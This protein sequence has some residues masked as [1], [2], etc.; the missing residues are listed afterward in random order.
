MP[1][2]QTIYRIVRLLAP[3]IPLLLLTT[4][5]HTL[6]LHEN[7]Q[8]WDLRMS[9]VVTLL[10]SIMAGPPTSSIS[11][12]QRF[13]SADPGIKGN[14]W[15][16][17]V[18]LPKPLEQDVL[19]KVL[20]AVEDLKRG[21]AEDGQYKRPQ[22]RDVEAE[23]TGDRAGIPP[24]TPEP[25][26]S[27][28][29]KY[30]RLMHE[31]ASSP[32]TEDCTTILYFHGG[33]H[34]LMDPVT[35]R[36]TCR[37]LA[38]LTRGRVLNVRYRLAPQN[39]FPAAI[40]DALLAYL[41]LLYPAQSSWHQPVK[42]EK[43][44]FAGDSAGGNLSLALLLLILHLHHTNK[45][46]LAFNGATV[47]VPLPAGVACMSA[48]CD[49]TRSLSSLRTNQQ[50]DYLPPPAV[51]IATPNAFSSL[52]TTSDL[53]PFTPHACPAW[54][55]TPPRCDIY[56]EGSML[57]HPLASP[58]AATAD[59]WRRTCPLFFNE[60]EEMMAD[61]VSVVVRRAV[62]G[63]AK[64]RWEGF[65]GM[66]HCFGAMFPGSPGGQRAFNGWA[67]FI[68][69]VTGGLARRGSIDKALEQEAQPCPLEGGVWI[70]A[71]TLNERPVDLTTLTSVT[72]EQCDDM[73]KRTKERRTEVFNRWVELRAKELER[74]ERARL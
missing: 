54:P 43:I 15:V 8:K 60:G 24:D 41:T 36:P 22:L 51:D 9:L 12:Q 47:H 40:V 68:A 39:P 33:A 63:G 28:R 19:L 69:S 56:C 16:A 31:T 73:M 11:A 64:V 67:G 1:S 26:V 72:D 42:P 30:A 3:R 62:Q 10:R 20:E 57:G 29:E 17:K 58:L 49:I 48:W 61:E 27:E 21:F 70:Q 74:G 23:W 71:K 14:T 18:T 53:A 5:T 13:S 50:F 32:E 45:A 65:E 44:V 2:T 37:K 59:M 66:P 7:A 38:Q 4:L 46:T 34:Y 35:H 55:S 52:A 25:N 6:N